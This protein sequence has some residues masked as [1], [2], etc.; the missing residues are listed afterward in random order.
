MFTAGFSNSAS[1]SAV[2][3]GLNGANNHAVL[4]AVASLMAM[5]AGTTCS[6]NALYVAGTITSGAVADILTITMIKN[7]SATTLATS[8]NVSTLNA[9]TT[10]SDTTP[11]HAFTVSP[12]DAVAIQLTQT[13]GAPTVRLS[14]ST[15]CQ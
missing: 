9:T 5:P 11:G 14:V 12:G 7:G 4:G 15:M 10:N 2:F 8:V 6:F 1:V 13:T 3:V